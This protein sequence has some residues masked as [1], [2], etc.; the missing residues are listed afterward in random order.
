[1]WNLLPCE[2]ELPVFHG[3]L[4]L[5]LHLIEQEKLDISAVSLAQVTEQYLSHLA[6]LKELEAGVL[7]DFL[8]VAARLIWIK[9]RLL[10]PASQT[11]G[12]ATSNGQPQS[13]LTPE[14]AESEDP[15]EALARQLQTYKRFK[16]AAKWLHEREQLDLRAYVRIAPAPAISRRLDMG[17][18]SIAD[19]L[20]AMQRVLA[21]KSTPMAGNT[22]QPLSVTIH[23]KISLVSRWLR[24]QATV[25]FR[26]LLERVADRVEIIVTLLAILE[27][28]KR[29]Q[30]IAEQSQLFGEILIR[31]APGANLDALDVASPNGA[32]LTP[33]VLP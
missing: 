26:S 8:V 28:I 4:D 11:N 31:L 18:V 10:L 7:A 22:V 16:E 14:E 9:S 2:I 27:L 12:T 29:Q 20:L 25:R 19:L 17:N 23:D 1:M 30:V 24:R 3:P 13:A 5:L 33:E 6:R 32:S 21:E 15:G